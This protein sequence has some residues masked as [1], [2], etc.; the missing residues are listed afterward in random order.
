M[1]KLIYIIAFIL[2]TFKIVAQSNIHINNYLENLYY[3]NPAAIDDE[4]SAN[5]SM[6]AR[7]QWVGFPG[8]P[9]TIYATGTTYLQ[10]IKTQFGLKVFNDK[11]GISNTFIIGLSYAYLV[12]IQANWKLHLGIAANFQNLSFNLT[13]LNP[14]YIDDP[15]FN[16]KL[17]KENNYNSDAGAQLTNKSLTLGVSSQNL[18]SIFFE[19]NKIQNNS[20]YIYAK[21]RYRT[22]TPINVQGGITGI[23]FVGLLQMEYNLTVF[24]NSYRHQD[25]FQIGVFYRT[26]TE[27]GTIFGINMGESMH[28]WYSF[29]YNVSGINKKTLGTHELMLVYR[30]ENKLSRN[31]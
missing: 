27:M 6:T 11:I 17:L 14:T 7:K 20:N 10:D 30:L 5:I 29:D 8:A 2:L 15:V 31:Y 24:F 21:Y 1:V 25:I 12:K 22:P 9:S 18:L 23:Q 28:L 19:E 3:I 13:D 16:S 4:S 26:K